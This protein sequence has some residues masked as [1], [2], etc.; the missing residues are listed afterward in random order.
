MS[1]LLINARTLISKPGMLFLYGKW[2]FLRKLFDKNPKLFC[3]NNSAISQWLNFSEYWSFSRGIPEAEK[4]LMQNCLHDSLHKK[5]VAIDIG[6]NI[7][8][9]AVT[10]A[11][12]GYS[13]VHVFEP[14]PQTFKRLQDNIKSNNFPGKIN[15]N[16]LALGSQTQK[17]EFQV[18]EHSPAINRFINC[19]DENNKNIVTQKVAVTTLTKYCQ[20]NNIE[21]I[22]F[23]KID[24]EGMEIFVLKGA[25]DLL[26][27]HRIDK[28]LL[29]IC[30]INL[31]S[32]NVKLQDLYECIIESKYLPY[33]LKNNGNPGK[34]LEI[35]DLE[36][37]TLENIVLVP[38][39]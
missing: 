8:L 10:L 15:L 32:A 19:Q 18:F 23:L 38:N 33:S 9:F 4:L 12:L 22:D 37:V 13:E 30:P 11:S 14:I 27:E 35:E 36:K 34:I 31:Q 5:T 1:S 7:G 6:A 25:K 39:R 2:L 28:I 21:H 20:E 24:V 26:Q 3:S 17:L 16:C 29:E